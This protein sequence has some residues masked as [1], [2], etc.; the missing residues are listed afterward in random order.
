MHIVVRSLRRTCRVV[1]VM[2]GVLRGEVV[3]FS[4][5][6]RWGLRGEEAMQDADARHEAFSF[7]YPSR[8]RA[9]LGSC[10]RV[11]GRG[12]GFGRSPL[13]RVNGE[14]GRR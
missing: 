5:V 10:V 3:G 4:A 14:R 12:M 8:A 2:G 11:M 7:R 6:E 13:W 1:F 9:G